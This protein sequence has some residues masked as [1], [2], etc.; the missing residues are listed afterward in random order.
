MGPAHEIVEVVSPDA[1]ERINP[2]RWANRHYL[3]VMRYRRTV[4]MQR[5]YS[6]YRGSERMKE[7]DCADKSDAPTSKRFKIVK[8]D[9]HH[10]DAALPGDYGGHDRGR[11][12][13]PRC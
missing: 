11:A 8:F 12:Q 3:Q 10:E 4:Q 9:P 6:C 5:G 1:K 7:I 2:T 13:R